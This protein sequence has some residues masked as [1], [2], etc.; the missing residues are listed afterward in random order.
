MQLTE[1]ICIKIFLNSIRTHIVPYGST[2]RIVASDSI[3]TAACS[4][5]RDYCRFIRTGDKRDL[6]MLLGTAYPSI[7]KCSSKS[8]RIKALKKNLL[9]GFHLGESSSSF[10]LGWC[11]YWFGT[12][13]PAQ[14]VSTYIQ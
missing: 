4:A 5:T 13:S 10:W 12:D 1:T 7:A 2:K 8:R 9:S 6:S 11:V 14:N 3:Q